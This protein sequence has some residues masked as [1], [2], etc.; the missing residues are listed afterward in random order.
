MYVA[1]TRAQN[2]LA[3]SSCQP[4]NVD[5]LSPWQRFAQID[6]A[7]VQDVAVPMPA[8]NATT[9]TQ[10]LQKAKEVAAAV[11]YLPIMPLAITEYAQAAIK[12]IANTKLFSEKRASKTDAQFIENKHTGSASS[13][14]PD[15]AASRIG[16]AMHRLLELYTPNMNLGAIAA[17]VGAQFQLT[18]A[19]TQ[20]ALQAAQRITQGEAA[21]VWDS[22]HIDWQANE[23][24]VLLNGNALRIDRLVKHTHTQTWWVLD[25]KSSDAPDRDAALREQLASYRGAVQAANPDSQVKSAFITAQGKL[26]QLP[27]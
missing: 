18:P 19:Q 10:L 1:A 23:V 17:A 20:Q 16:Q 3:V 13:N 2:T 4:H 24:E 12:N 15:S 21:W 5:P 25:F 11:F 9:Q 8:D 26:L 7:L 14:E 6:A 22:A 27:A